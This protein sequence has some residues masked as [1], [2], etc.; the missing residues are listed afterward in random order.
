MRSDSMD[1]RVNHKKVANVISALVNACS[2]DQDKLARLLC[3]LQED[4]PNTGLGYV[5]TQAI[6]KIE[7][8][9]NLAL[10]S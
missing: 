1:G 3:V 10:V 7:A 6:A 2:D 9:L 5:V 4:G 8:K